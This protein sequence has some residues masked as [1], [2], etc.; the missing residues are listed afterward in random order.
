LGLGFDGALNSIGQVG[1]DRALFQLAYSQPSGGQAPT[2]AASADR[3]FDP[4]DIARGNVMPDF[5]PAGW[6]Q[7]MGP[8]QLFSNVMDLSLGVSDRSQT[9]HGINIRLGATLPSLYI[10]SN[11]VRRVTLAYDQFQ[12]SGEFLN[13]YS[14]PGLRRFEPPRRWGILHG[15]LLSYTWRNEVCSVLLQYGLHPPHEGYEGERSIAVLMRFG[16]DKRKPS[17]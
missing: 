8:G 3:S 6:F 7:E 1:S 15:G 12:F 10:P 9:N 5:A 17:H 16:L 4:S 14:L 2:T 13:Q 11:A